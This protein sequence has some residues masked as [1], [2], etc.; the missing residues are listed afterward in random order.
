MIRKTALLTTIA[1][2]LFIGAPALAQEQAAEAPATQEAAQ[3]QS[4]SLNPG[5]AVMGS[6]G[7]E[8]GKLVGV[9]NGA[10]GQELTVRGVD[11]ELRPVPVAGIRQDGTNIV[12]GASS[13]DFL[14][15]TAIAE[16]PEAP[17]PAPAPAPV[18]EPMPAAEPAEADT[19]TSDAAPADEATAE[20]PAEEPR[21]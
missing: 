9:Q 11:G 7:V 15:A 8:L 4:L 13:A 1:G 19:M 2:T 14:A 17:M 10:T 12:V 3:P 20:A 18:A 16:E 6:D 21:A 5:S